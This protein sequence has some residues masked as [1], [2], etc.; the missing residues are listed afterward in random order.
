MLLFLMLIL[1]HSEGFLKILLGIHQ[2]V[3]LTTDQ[4]P[5]FPV[6]EGEGKEQVP[7]CSSHALRGIMKWGWQ[8]D[9][10]LQ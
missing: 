9:K 2:T 7:S 3:F 8:K 1:S 4:L 5:V 10:L 6:L